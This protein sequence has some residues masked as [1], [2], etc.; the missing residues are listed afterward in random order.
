MNGKL[1]Q[2]EWRKDLDNAGMLPMG[3][4]GSNNFSSTAKEIREQFKNYFNFEEGSVS[5]QMDLVN[6]VSNPGEECC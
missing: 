4:C 2:G 1:K 5:W 6:R 3:R